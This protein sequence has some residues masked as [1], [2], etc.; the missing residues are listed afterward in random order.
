MAMGRIMHRL[1]SGERWWAAEIA[2]RSIGLATLVL[3]AAAALWLYRSMHQPP[4]HE[5][6]ALEYGAA[7]VAFLSWS[8]GWAFL[9]EGPGLFKLV[10]VPARYRRFTL[11]S[12]DTG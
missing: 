5:A 7:L 9:V 1:E 12:K 2:L 10:P 11:N 3:C 8:L 4:R 6:R